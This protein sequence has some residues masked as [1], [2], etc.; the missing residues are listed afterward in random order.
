M[1]VLDGCKLLPVEHQRSE[2]VFVFLFRKDWI[3]LAFAEQLF[4]PK[5]CGFVQMGEIVFWQ[6]VPVNDV[7]DTTAE[8][9]ESIDGS[10]LGLGEVPEGTE[11]G[12][13]GCPGDVFALQIRSFKSFHGGGAVFGQKET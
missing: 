3:D 2:P 7:I 13:R 4:H 11:K 5:R 9:I 1:S 12:R 10:A 8:C 6:P